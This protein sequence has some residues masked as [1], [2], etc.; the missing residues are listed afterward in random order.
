[1]PCMFPSVLLYIKLHFYN[2]YDNKHYYY[3]LHIQFDLYV[4][5][6]DS[7]VRK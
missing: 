4:K 3:Y 6:A 1:M 5:Y 2:Y 7:S